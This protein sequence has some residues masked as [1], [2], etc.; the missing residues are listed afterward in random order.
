MRE[1]TVSAT[2]FTARDRLLLAAFSLLVL[3]PGVFGV[4]LADRDEGWYAQVSREMFTSGDWLIP[5]YLGEPWL[6]KPPLLYWCVAASFAAF[7]VHAWAARL[8]S[9]LAMAGA[10]QLVASLGAAL[11]NRRVA[12]I[13]AASFITAGLPVVIGK[14]VLTDGLLLA[15]CLGAM[16]L[17]WRMA[18]RGA[19]LG[20]S[21]G[22]WLL[23]GLA[24]LAKGPAVFVFV[25]A[26]A[27]GLVL[28]KRALAARLWSMFP[29]CLAIA[30]PWYI[31]VGQHA[32]ATF[33]QQFVGFEIVSRLF[34]TPHGHGGPPGYYVALSLAGWLPWTVLLPGAVFATW[35]ARRADRAARLLLIWCGAAWLVLE[36]IPSKLPHYILPCY[37]PL[38]IMLGRMWDSGLTRVLARRERHV[39]GFWI[40]AMILVGIALI[41]A[42][43][44]WHELSW[45]VAGAVL[46]IGFGVVAGMVRRR[47]LLAAW[48]SALAATVLS[49]MVVGVWALP[50]LEPYRLSRR[51]AEAANELSGPT[52]RVL[53]CGYTE[54]TVFFYL[55]RPAHVVSAREIQR[56]QP[57]TVLIVRDAEA[58][59]AGLTPDADGWHPLE[60]LNIANLRREKV[61]VL[62][63]KTSGRAVG[64]N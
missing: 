35:Q 32:G 43:S 17:L 6:A 36:L 55:R 19:G 51:I 45:G 1:S 41:A 16:V 4:S 9:V 64:G 11:G 14:L 59:A 8:V 48:G 31:Y 13:A 3:L 42:A 60:G 21:L 25:G 53:A 20:R 28:T 54:P 37:V 26:F 30:A 34:S 44:T 38:A 46:A 5:H 2:S 49:H 62:S 58:R 63:G 61:W 24:I 15:C 50:G 12:W 10:V 52:T 23:V 18:T 39:L 56:P 22:F 27:L 29:V 7:G 47:R 33:W 57:G 40:G